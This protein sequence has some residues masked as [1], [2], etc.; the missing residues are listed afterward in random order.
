MAV[1]LKIKFL[2]NI[3]CKH[4]L[5]L[6]LYFTGR[7]TITEQKLEGE[8]RHI[9]SRLITNS[10]EIAFYNGNNR[11][12]I[13]LLASFKKLIDHLRKYLWFKTSMGVVD[14]FVAKYFATVI[15]FWAVS[16]PFMSPTHSLAKDSEN[17]RFR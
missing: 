2:V 14:N 9:N 15:G 8:F 5:I 7:L 12:R 10:E 11:E 1:L 4:K 17:E 13:T 3:F 6:C 16:R